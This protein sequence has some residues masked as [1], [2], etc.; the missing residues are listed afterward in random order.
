MNTQTY[1][2]M[3]P[4]FFALAALTVATTCVALPTAPAVSSRDITVKAE[5][6]RL[7]DFVYNDKT[8]QVVMLHHRARTYAPLDA[9]TFKAMKAD[10][11]VTKGASDQRMASARH[12]MRAKFANMP[13]AQRARMER[14]MAN[15]PPAQRAK[16]QAMLN[17]QL[18]AARA[19]N[20]PAAL[21]AQRPAPKNKSAK[22]IGKSMK[23]GGVPCVTW[24]LFVDKRKI[25]EVCVAKPKRLG[26]SATEWKTTLRGIAA[27]RAQIKELAKVMV[28]PRM[29]RTLR[30]GHLSN[31][32]RLLK[33]TGGWPLAR[34]RVAKKGKAE[35]IWESNP[36]TL[37][38][39]KKA[40]TVR[41]PKGYTLRRSFRR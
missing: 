8:G 40:V 9:A 34:K 36:A 37:S 30:G 22:R 16:M 21:N 31:M 29:A 20:R 5:H 7:G 32:K 17:G 14:A 28:N 6:L 25:G 4:F 41:I 18:P 10:M 11:A 26:L 1:T 2:A 33:T 39:A 35:T 24:A 38:V 27:I 12:A 15:M 23:F 3:I 13:P 19:S